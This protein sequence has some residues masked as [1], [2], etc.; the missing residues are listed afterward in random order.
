M[1]C[2]FN[3]EIAPA[4]AHKHR[5]R[6]N[7][8]LRLFAASKLP[9]TLAAAAGCDQ[10][11][12][13]PLPAQPAEECVSLLRTLEVVE[14]QFQRSGRFESKTQLGDHLPR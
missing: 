5:L 14:T 4:A 1:L 10:R 2:N 8:E 11:R 13:E 7:I 6:Q 12:G 3:F 9:T